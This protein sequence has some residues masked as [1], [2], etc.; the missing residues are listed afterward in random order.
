MS[1]SLTCG[2]TGNDNT[3]SAHQS[4]A[5]KF[6]PGDCCAQLWQSQV[7]SKHSGVVTIDHAMVSYHLYFVCNPVVIG[8][9]CAAFT[10]GENFACIHAKAA[11]D[12]KCPGL[13]LF[14]CR[15]YRLAGVLYN[16][17]GMFLCNFIDL[18]DIC[19]MTVEMHGYHNLG[20]LCNLVLQVR[21]IHGVIVLFH[22]YK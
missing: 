20:F 21:D 5:G 3:W 19:R 13:L 8:G 22:I 1:A 7:Q 10:C 18:V 2:C 12:A 4:V 15:T 11:H 14:V 9:N 17:K 16:F 6:V